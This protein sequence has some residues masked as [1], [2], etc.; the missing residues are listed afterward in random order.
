MRTITCFG[1]QTSCTF[2]IIPSVSLAKI[3]RSHRPITFYTRV[4]ASFV[5]FST[6]PAMQYQLC[7][8]YTFSIL[9]IKKKR[10]QRRVTIPQGQ[11]HGSSVQ[12]S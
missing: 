6:F 5:L 12:Q 9:E 8:F 4:R 3:T 1:D 2:L 10:V 11:Q 7:F